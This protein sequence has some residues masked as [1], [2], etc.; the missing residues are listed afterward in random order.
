MRSALLTPTRL[1]TAIAALTVC[2]MLAASVIVDRLAESYLARSVG[3]PSIRV[4]LIHQV[5]EALNRTRESSR[6]YLATGDQDD[7]RSY[8]AASTEVDA[9]LARLL[10]QDQD[11]KRKIS[12]VAELPGAVHNKLSQIGDSLTNS[13]GKAATV[14]DDS[15]LVRIGKLL[16]SLAAAEMV[17]QTDELAAAGA[18]TTFHHNL[19]LALG[20][21]NIL[22]L[23][24]VAFCA[25]QIQ[26]LQKLITMCAWSKR[27]QYEG[28][29]I[30]LEEYLRKRFGIRFSHGISQEEYDKWSAVSDE[31]H[32]TV[33]AE[34]ANPRA[35]A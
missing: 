11:I 17:D 18:R 7:I 22:F 5:I 20:T 26:K 13:G 3:G 35:A 23:S 25:I 14:V 21:I 9:S 8:R 2:C 28:N 24:G 19:L 10:A 15:D 12:N 4:H 32:A 1:L 16:D 33:P 31:E 6:E 29:W 27:V 30:P 34:Q